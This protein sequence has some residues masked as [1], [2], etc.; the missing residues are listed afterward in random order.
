MDRSVSVVPILKW[1][2]G[3]RW[4]IEKTNVFFPSHFGR[5]VEPFL[6]SAAV[7]FHLAPH[8]AVLSDLNGSLIETYS[9]IRDSW[10]QVLTY[11]RK[12]QRLHSREYY[13][14]VRDTIP[15][16]LEARA[17]R[18]LY[19]NRTCWNGLYRVNL[20][21]KFNV[22]IGTKTKVLLQSDNFQLTASRLRAATLITCDF[23]SSIERAGTGDF[24]FADPPYTVKHNINGF[25]KYN[26]KIFS[27]SDQIRLREALGRAHD[28]GAKFALSNAAHKSIRELYEDFSITRLKRESVIAGKPSGRGRTEELLIR[29]Y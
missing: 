18:F 7:F 25:L 11:L 1:A 17:A 21:G 5:Y 3:K 9:A 19:L 12:H 13:Y 22:P 20:Q 16:K 10:E 6:G 4:L 8:E 28:R 2:G 15:R 14:L 27:W 26:E 29:N 24:I 23:E